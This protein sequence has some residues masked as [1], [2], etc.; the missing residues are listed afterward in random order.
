M[1]GITEGYQQ[2]GEYEVPTFSRDVVDSNVLTVEVGTRLVDD[3]KAMTYFMLKDEGCTNMRVYPF[4]NGKKN[5]GFI[6]ELEGA[7][8]L[9][10]FIKALKFAVKVLED[11]R[12]DVH[13]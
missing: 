10:T 4:K 1:Y 6:L 13:D 11:E 8:E 9:N 12:D 7:S 5:E 2:V 3:G